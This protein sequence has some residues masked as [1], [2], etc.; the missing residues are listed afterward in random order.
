V[1]RRTV[2]ETYVFG[3]LD[4][5]RHF[6]Y[7]DPSTWQVLEERVGTSTSANRQFVWGVRYVDDLIVRDRDTN[8]DG[9]LDE[10]LYAM[11]DANWNVTSIASN[12]STME[13]RFSYHPYGTP[14]VL[15]AAFG[16]RAASDSGWETTFAGYRWDGVPNF[17]QVRH[18]VLC[19]GIGAWLQRDLLRPAERTG[20][21]GYA[22]AD[23]LGATDPSGLQVAGGLVEIPAGLSFAAFV[24]FMLA[25]GVVIVSLAVWHNKWRNCY[26][27][28]QRCK[29][30]L[31][32]MEANSCCCHLLTVLR[33]YSVCVLDH[34][35]Q[36]KRACLQSYWE[37]MFGLPFRSVFVDP[38]M[39][40]DKRY[41]S[42]GG[43][44]GSDGGS[45]PPVEPRPEIGQGG[46]VTEP[47]PVRA[48]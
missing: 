18:R 23:P 25:I 11:Q 1:K 7:T 43:S 40:C 35:A 34:W 2:K 21:Y 13:E 42:E 6:F 32:P 48:L 8:S 30:A 29:R 17:Y 15:T 37:C 28:Y 12:T 46:V 26:L 9:S 27:P 10:R 5:T 36:F 44:N 4:E 33:W 41:R 31:A 22:N 39:P 38:P 24:G 14:M 47:V 20:L 16:L 45:D 3:E 19:L